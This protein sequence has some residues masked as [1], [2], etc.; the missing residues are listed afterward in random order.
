MDEMAWRYPEREFVVH[1]G[2]RVTYAQFRGRTRQLAKGLHK[3]GVRKGDH[4]GLL[5][6]NQVEFL[7]VDFAVNLLGGVLVALNTWYKSHELRY[8]LTHGDVSV[9]VLAERFLG[10]DYIAMLRELDVPGAGIPA[11]RSVVCLGA[12]PHA[13]LLPFAE[14]W[15]MGAD[16]PE[17]TLDAAQRAVGPRDM[18]A[19]LYT[20]GTTS[21]PKGVPLLHF[22]LIENMFNIGERQHL[23]EQDRMWHGV[24]LFWALGCVNALFAVM[25]HGGCL[26]LQ[27]AFEP[28]EALQIIERERCT[29]YYGTPNMHIAMV[30]HPD[31][32]RR[33]LSS[34]RS[35]V[36]IGNPQAMR[37]AMRLGATQICQCYGLTES[38]GNCCI[39]DAEA[40]EH[41]RAETIGTPLPDTELL[42]GDPVTHRPLPQGE[43][44]EIKIRGPYILSGYYKQPEHTAAAFDADGFFLTGDLGWQDAEGY[45]HFQTRIKEMVK[46][47]G[48]NVAP[49]EVEEFLERQPGVKEAFIVGVPD[50]LK[51]EVI[52]AVIVPQAGVTLDAAALQAA[53][54]AQLAAYKVPRYIRFATRDA[55]PAT[56]TG[57]VQ[58]VKLKEQMADWAAQAEATGGQHVRS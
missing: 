24:T 1:G 46:S 26:V 7:L 53:C 25:T 52:A 57:K 10:Q 30:N 38:Y 43:L 47:G 8:V 13:G 54:K 20:S 55:L 51:D 31:F 37:T 23:S 12:A 27:H 36:A 28:G 18:A 45:F 11:I 49:M 2:E 16:V 3:L 4:V 48:I 17:A 15:A 40:P 58:K 39:T 41:I 6:G 21:F 33:D 44:G 32:S 50:A 42:I 35:G 56:A 5:M 29:I 14:L 9:L 19:L 22:G 34:L